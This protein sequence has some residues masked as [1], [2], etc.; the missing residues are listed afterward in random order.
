M[1]LL[2]LCFDIFTYI[3]KIDKSLRRNS[4]HQN[5]YLKVMYSD[6]KIF[7]QKILRNLSNINDIYISKDMTGNFFL[8]NE[9]FFLVGGNFRYFNG[10]PYKFRECWQKFGQ[11]SVDLMVRTENH[12][13]NVYL[14]N[15]G[16]RKYGWCFFLSKSSCMEYMSHLLTW[17]Y[18][19]SCQFI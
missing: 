4:P 15:D 17:R 1:V 16:S 9:V 11:C 10:Q 14:D 13:V 7:F 2:H 12:L 19:Q 5:K 6:E 3:P 8:W 18:H